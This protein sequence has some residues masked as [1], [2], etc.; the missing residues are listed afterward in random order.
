MTSQT[1]DAAELLTQAKHA[2]AAKDFALA[3]SKLD[4]LH[5][6]YHDRPWWHL[7]VHLQ[8]FL[9]GLKMQSPKK[10][11]QE[12]LPIVFAVPVSLVQKTTGISRKLD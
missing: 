3:T 8:S 12:L 6:H 7:Q 11:L 2:L 1:T 10:M 4:Q 9:L 5:K